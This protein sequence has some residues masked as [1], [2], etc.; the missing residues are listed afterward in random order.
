MGRGRIFDIQF[1]AIFEDNLY[2]ELANHTN[3]MAKKLSDGIAQL[4]FDFLTK[5]ES[6]Q[7]FPILPNAIIG[8]L[9]KAFGIYAWQKFDEQQTAIRLVCS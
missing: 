2:F 9:E 7:I 8:K 5:P 6:N 1:Q 4:G 3:L